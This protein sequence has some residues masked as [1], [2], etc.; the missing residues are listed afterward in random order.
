[1]PLKKWRNQT[2]CQPG[3]FF[4]VKETVSGLVGKSLLPVKLYFSYKTQS[5]QKLP[6]KINLC[7]RDVIFFWP[8]V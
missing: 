5:Y 8:V 4:F 2:R 7:E 1:M 6:M 3:G